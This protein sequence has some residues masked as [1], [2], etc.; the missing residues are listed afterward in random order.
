[1]L[2]SSAARSKG[3]WVAMLAALVLVLA[4]M[5]ILTSPG[6]HPKAAQAQTASRAVLACDG[7][8]ETAF[9][10]LDEATSSIKL[11]RGDGKA[12]QL[13]PIRV[14]LERTATNDTRLSDWHQQAVK[15]LTGY[16]KNC[17][18]TF[19]ASDGTPTLKLSL[20]NAWPVEYHLEQ[21]GDQVLE[22]VTLTA[23]SI[24]R[25]VVP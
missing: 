23:S 2:R 13:E 14:V 21:Q 12:A 16:K 9:G 3:T 17:S 22:R 7:G 8:L 10:K 1:M 11:P 6:S 4:L 18:L 15:Q 5:V 25:V 20:D 24:Q 19:Y